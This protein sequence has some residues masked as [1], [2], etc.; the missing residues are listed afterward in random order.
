[1]KLLIISLLIL[2][3]LLQYKL[4]FEAGGVKHVCQLKD[5]VTLQ[6]K[7]NDQLRQRN[8]TLAAE[9]QDLKQG[10]DA[11]E[12]RARNDLGMVKPGEEFYQIVR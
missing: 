4:W 6:M 3:A 7:Q 1:M 12:E 5:K 10:Q 9:I 8:T 11:V 2:L